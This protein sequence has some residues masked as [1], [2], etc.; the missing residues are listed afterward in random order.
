MGGG[1]P[2]R[3]QGMVKLPTTDIGGATRQVESLA[4]LGAELVRLAVPDEESARALRRIVRASPVPIVADCHFDW[5]LALLALEAGAAKVRVNP[6]TMKLGGGG[7]GGGIAEFARAAKE[8]GAA[9]RVGLNEGSVGK[10]DAPPPDL[11]LAMVR[12]ALEWCGRFEEAGLD[13]LVVSL[14]ASTVRET[15][16]ANRLFAGKSDVPLHIGVTAAGPR[17]SAIIKSAAAMGALLLDG[18]GE[19]VRVSMTGPPEDEVT[20]AVSIL[21]ALGLREGGVDIVSCPTCGRCKVDLVGLVEEF[22]ARVRGLPKK[23]RVALM[24]CVVNGPGEAKGADVGLACD[25]AGGV[26]FKGG[27]RLRRVGREGMLEELLREVL[28]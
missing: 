21:R 4:R 24:G 22:E 19:T 12:V 25:G 13:A 7:G 26:I 28:R 11:A 1:E 14:K 9:V 20:A 16:E 17:S 10:G 5:R 15:V 23:L 8:R 6:G 3:V 18:I 27:K 2:V